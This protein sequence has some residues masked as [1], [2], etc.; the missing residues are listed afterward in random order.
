MDHS[1]CTWGGL[2]TL[3]PSRVFVVSSM[4]A[5]KDIMLPPPWQEGGSRCLQMGHHLVV[6]QIRG[7]QYRPQNTMVLIMGNVIGYP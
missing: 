7:P 6:S 2:C 4:F 3:Q 5:V 1:V